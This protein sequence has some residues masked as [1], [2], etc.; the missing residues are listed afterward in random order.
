M[1]KPHEESQETK[2][3]LAE[4]YA[5][6]NEVPS[7]VCFPETNKLSDFLH[8]IDGV[9]SKV[10]DLYVVSSF[11]S[12]FDSPRTNSI[13]FLD[14]LLEDLHNMLER[15]VEFIPS[16]KNRVIG[17]H[18]GL[19]LLRPFL[20]YDLE[21]QSE[22]NKFRN[23]Q[24]R[25]VNVINFATYVIKLCATMS[26]SVWFGI[27]CLPIVLQDIKLVKCGIEEIEDDLCL[28]R[29]K[30]LTTEMEVESNSS[31]LPR[32]I[33]SNHEG[34]LI[35]FR[36]DAKSILN[37]LLGG[38]KALTIISISGM[39]GQGKTTLA[40]RIFHDPSI[41][42]HFHKTAWCF[43]GKECKMKEL[44]ASILWFDI[45]KKDQEKWEIQE[46]ANCLR[47]SLKGK[48][49]FVVL[50][51]IWDVDMWRQ[52]EE[53]F[54]DDRNGSRI[55]FTSR[56]H[57]LALQ[58]KPNSV[59]HSLPLFSDEESLELAKDILSYHD[60]F[61]SKLLEVGREIAIRCK[62]LPL[63][64]ALIASYLKCIPQ[65]LD[66]WMK[67]AKNLKSHL[68]SE[69]CMQIIEHS[70]KN[71]PIHLKPCLLYFGAF[72]RGAIV[73]AGVLMHHWIA[74]GWILRNEQESS[75]DLARQY[76]D[77]LVSQ[78]LVIVI[79]RGSMGTIKRCMVH[80]LI[81][82]LCLQKTLEDNLLQLVDCRAIPQEYN[83]HQRWLS[84]R[85]N[86]L[87]LT[88]LRFSST[89]KN[90]LPTNQVYSLHWCDFVPTNYKIVCDFLS[91]FRVLT[92]LDTINMRLGDSTV[93]EIILINIHLRY[94]ALRGSFR[95]IPRSLA[96]L[97]NLET[98]VIFAESYILQLP[99]FL[100]EIKS[101]RS[102]RVEKSCTDFDGFRRNPSTMAAASNVHTLS[103][104]I[105]SYNVEMLEFLRSLS[106]LRKLDCYYDTELHPKWLSMFGSLRKLESLKIDRHISFD[107]IPDCRKNGRTNLPNFP[108]TLKKLCLWH[109]GLPWKAMSVIGK[110]PNLQVLKLW[111]D[112]FEGTT[113]DLGEG[114]FSSLRLEEV[115]SSFGDICTLK[116]INLISSPKVLDS[117]RAIER[118]QREVGNHDFHLFVSDHDDYD[119]YS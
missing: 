81:Y 7:I 10:R 6:I 110:L 56:N 64:V 85:Y 111:W 72:P 66:L 69:G 51:D 88:Q 78:N 32:G 98:L 26:F 118:Q 103:G 33:T 61:P 79:Q 42:Y 119:R 47:K 4:I 19:S 105:I 1:D 8:K 22:D 70:Y 100:W 115:P 104:V 59:S 35:G 89:N 90:K 92:I 114:E 58:S 41:R 67:V 3:I 11:A 12:Q 93:P 52:V 44:M 95:F 107:A 55:L 13:G 87:N 82:D 17:V 49:Y 20:Q 31:S 102:L 106:R 38:E 24:T 60:G 50:D 40:K 57:D 34:A 73:Y 21:L 53:S 108:D 36:E 76:L 2:L 18:D 48:R 27:I 75:K 77:Y 96:T 9:K 86:W 54:P 29:S 43:V 97:W 15:G 46:L 74:Q 68:A 30:K 71:L 14:T 23:L 62:G 116:T 112:A 94:L 101:L 28:Y 80:D 84:I 45:D 37:H 5:M 16:V 63:A 91:N 65:E 25:I 99:N 39:P 117:M 109:I 83:H 113:W